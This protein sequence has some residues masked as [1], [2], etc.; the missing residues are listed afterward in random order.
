MSIINEALKKAQDT[1]KELSQIVT[2]DL[3]FKQSIP[4]DKEL[5]SSIKE[6]A[7][8]KTGWSVASRVGTLFIVGVAVL[9]FLYNKN[10][11]S[12][13]TYPTAAVPKL[14]EVERGAVKPLIPPPLPIVE[15]AA[16]SSG[17][18][19][20]TVIPDFKLSGVMSGSGDSFVMLNNKIAT[21]G[22]F[23]DGAQIISIDGDGATLV[24]DGRE[25]RVSMK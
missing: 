22:D 19:K 24:Y 10:I 17:R 2:K 11:V 25:L 8:K 5:S 23:V 6:I 9:A 14:L 20:V 13:T 3:S 21:I 15:K 1:K 12:P 16:N 18:K 7:D 4:S